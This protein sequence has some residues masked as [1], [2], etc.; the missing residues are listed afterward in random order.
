MSLQRARGG[1][2]VGKLCRASDPAM[3]SL[4]A[5]DRTK[6]EAIY[7]S[8]WDEHEHRHPTTRAAGLA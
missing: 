3:S 4:V 1:A 7:E 5:H 8:R 6:H 2:V